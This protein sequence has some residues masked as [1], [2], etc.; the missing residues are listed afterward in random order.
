MYLLL[1]AS[2]CHAITAISVDCGELYDDD[3]QSRIW[4]YIYYSCNGTVVADRNNTDVGEL[5]GLHKYGKNNSYVQRLVLNNQNLT[6]FPT[7]LMAIFP[8]LQHIV[9]SSNN[10]T[11]LTNTDLKPHTLL[12]Q[13][14]ID[15]NQITHLAAN[16]FD[17][18]DNLII[19]DL[20]SNRI[21]SI[22][23]GIVIP[24]KLQIRLRNNT[25]IDEER[26]GLAETSCFM[27]SIVKQCAQLSI[28]TS[29]EAS[30]ANVES[31]STIFV[32]RTQMKEQEPI[33]ERPDFNVKPPKMGDLMHCHLKKAFLEMAPEDQK[34][35][36]KEFSGVEEAVE[37][38]KCEEMIRWHKEE[39][40]AARKRE[41]VDF[42][43]PKPFLQ[44]I[45]ENGQWQWRTFIAQIVDSP[46]W[47]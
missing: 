38:D 19:V 23:H 5:L 44:R 34:H 2:I 33:T 32:D 12:N 35:L 11:R 30:M 36:F 20:T 8:H 39:R 37:D 15:N 16:L 10:I 47:Q 4:G 28:A 26:T 14:L 6:S 27:S 45:C 7:N 18:M 22:D 24:P 43:N 3:R 42:A 29:N 17:G 13:L 1:I 31:F 25:C 9:L 40:E 41:K 46:H 21:S